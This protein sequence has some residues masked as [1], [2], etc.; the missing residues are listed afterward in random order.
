VHTDFEQQTNEKVSMKFKHVNLIISLV[1]VALVFTFVTYLVLYSTDLLIGTAFIFVLLLAIMGFL[2]KRMIE[3]MYDLLVSPPTP[4]KIIDPFKIVAFDRVFWQYP[5]EGPFTFMDVKNAQISVFEPPLQST[6]EN[7]V[8][9]KT[10]T[11][12]LQKSKPG[13]KPSYS[14]EEQFQI[15]K[16]Y[17]DSQK[18]G[19]KK[20]TYNSIAAKY[21]VSRETIKGYIGKYQ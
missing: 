2:L 17:L 16:E 14:E 19:G 11:L 20:E 5:K 6:E 13:P 3:Q 4:G 21:H 8:E 1:V 15:A 7:H 12:P 10:R 18:P 9:V